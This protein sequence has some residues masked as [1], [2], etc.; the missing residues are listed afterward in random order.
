MC[1]WVNELISLSLCTQPTDSKLFFK[2]SIN[3]RLIVGYPRLIDI[4]K[5]NHPV[6][7]I[8]TIGF[9]TDCRQA[10]LSLLAQN[11]TKKCR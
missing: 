5:I 2:S 11:V 6:A 9:D 3:C 7:L 10:V 1:S 4:K 8:C